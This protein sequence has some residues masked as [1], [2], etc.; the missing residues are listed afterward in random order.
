MGS[1]SDDKN[2]ALYVFTDWQ[3][4]K[5]LILETVEWWRG[6]ESI[7]LSDPRRLKAV[8]YKLKL[9]RFGLLTFDQLQLILYLYK[10]HYDNDELSFS[11][12]IQFLS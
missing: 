7:Q 3:L 6:A 11:V 12:F 10:F 4:P 2:D 8:V 9:D 5:T 1:K